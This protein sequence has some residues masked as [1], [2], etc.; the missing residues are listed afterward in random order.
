MVNRLILDSF[1]SMPY[2]KSLADFLFK[3]YPESDQ[4]SLFFFT[5][6]WDK[7]PV[8]LTPILSLAPYNTISAQ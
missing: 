8:F 5:A 3:T 6:T 7:T 1:L 2:S 4:S